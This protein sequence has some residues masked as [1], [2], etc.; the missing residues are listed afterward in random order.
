[1]SLRPVQLEGARWLSSRS[2]ALLADAP[3][4]GKTR[5]LLHAAAELGKERILV[6]CP[7]I[8]ETHWVRE[9]EALGT[10]SRP[11]VYSYDM[12][13][14]HGE[15]LKEKILRGIK[16]DLLILDESHYLKTPTS[17]RTKLLLGKAGYAKRVET[18]WAATGT[19]M[20]KHPGELWTTLVA[21]WPEDCLREGWRTQDD[22]EETFC[23]RVRRNYGGAVRGGVWKYLGS[24][25]EERLKAFLAPRMLRRLPENIRIDWQVVSLELG[26]KLPGEDELNAEYREAL[27]AGDVSRIAQDPKLARQRRRYGELKAPRAAAWIKEALESGE[28]K[29]VVLA[30][31]RAVLDVLREELEEY[32][33]VYVDGDTP[34]K[35]RVRAMDEFQRHGSAVR[36][37]LGQ[38]LT[39]QTGITLSAA[40][41]CYLVEPDWTSVVNEQAGNRILDATT[42]LVGRTVQMLVLDGTVEDAVIRVNAREQEMQSKVLEV[43]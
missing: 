16:P 31:H 28:P 34:Q 21:F 26:Y 17:K 37:F 43:S 18:V 40:K 22:F 15:P 12:L 4:V 33:L 9:A 3:R 1:M 41:V 14:Y 13:R 32:G 20:P 8:V 24:K 11:F 30:H 6:V 36:V 29:V 39:C 10:V 42:P 2:R 7:S 35:A 38:T 23:I 5:T 25:N 19:P 27:A